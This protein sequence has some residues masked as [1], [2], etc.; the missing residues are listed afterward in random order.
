MNMPTI[1][2]L[3]CATVARA[4]DPSAPTS[5]WV[6]A[7]TDAT[8]SMAWYGAA[9]ADGDIARYRI[10]RDG[11]EVATPTTTNW[12]DSGLQ[13][14][15]VYIYTIVVEDVAGHRSSASAAL[16]AITLPAGAAA[17]PA[18]TGLIATATGCHA[19]S[20]TWTAVTD[21]DPIVRYLIYVDGVLTAASTTPDITLSGLAAGSRG[22]TVRAED[23][24]G[25]Q[26]VASASASATILADLVAPS[27]PG[28]VASAAVTA[29]TMMLSWTAATDN[30][31]VVHYQLD[32]LRNGVAAGSWTT[33]GLNYALGAQNGAPLVPSSTYTITVSAVDGNA[34]STAAAPVVV[35]TL[36]DASPPSRPAP[37]RVAVAD[38]TSMQLAWVHPP[39]DAG[40]VTME[41]LRDGVVLTTTNSG[42]YTDTTVA[43]AIG[44]AYTLVAIDAAGNRSQPSMALAVAA[45][46]ESVAP[47]AP[48]GLRVVS[49]TATSLTFDWQ[50][51]PDVGSGV[52][53]WSIERDGVVIA[54]NVA[55]KPWIDTAPTGQSHTWTVRAI[56]RCGNSSAPSTAL[57]LQRLGDLLPPAAPATP[58]LGQSTVTTAVIDWV[59]VGGDVVGYEIQRD[60]FLVGTSSSTSWTDADRVPASTVTYTVVAYDA[61][62]NHSPPSPGVVSTTPADITAPSVPTNLSASA[63]APDGF[64][65][66]WTGSTDDHRVA[67]Y[68][69]WRAGVQI[70]TAAGTSVILTGLPVGASAAYTVRAVDPTGNASADATAVTVATLAD[71]TAPSQ[72]QAP[73]AAATAPTAITLAWMACDDDVAV[74]SYEIHRDGFVVATTTSPGW[75]DTAVAQGGSYAYALVAIDGVGNRSAEGPGATITVPW[76]AGSDRTPPSVPG[77]VRVALISDR[78]IGIAWDASTDNLPANIKHYVISVDG[79]VVTTTTATSI[80]INALLPAQDY[81]LAVQAEDNAGNRSAASLPFIV[82]TRND[83]APPTVPAGLVASAIG[84]TSFI[85]T[86]QPAVDDIAVDFYEITGPVRVDGTTTTCTDLLPGTAITRSVRAVDTAGNRSGWASIQVTTLPDTIAPSVPT[87]LA[88]ANIT[89]TT[90]TV[91]WTASTDDAGVDRYEVRIGTTTMGSTT[92]TSFQLTGLAPATAKSCTVR[93]IDRTGNAS[94]WSTALGFTNLTDTVSPLPPDGVRITSVTYTSVNLA[95]IAGTDDVA[96]T[97]YRIYVDGVQ[98]A[99]STGT[100]VTVNGL[101]SNQTYTITVRAL[102]A[103]GNVSSD[104]PSIQL[105]M[106]TDGVAPPMPDW[107]TFSTRTTSSIKVHW[108]ATQPD[109]GSGIAGFRVRR[110]GTVV[111]TLVGTGVTNYTIT[112]LSQ[113]TPYAITVASYDNG[114]NES[115]PTFPVTIQLST[116]TVVPTKATNLAVTGTTTNSVSLSWT[117]GTDNIAVAQYLVL[118]NNIVVGATTGTTFT[119]AGVQPSTTGTY[120]LWT[121]DTSGNYSANSTSVSG[122]T[123]ADVTTPTAPGQPVA[124]TMTVKSVPLSWPAGTDET[125][126]KE[127]RVYRNGTLAATVSGTS[128]TD[129]GVVQ[130]QS[131][132]YLVY[133]RDYANHQ[134]SASPSCVVTVPADVTAPAQPG[135]VHLTS[136]TAASIAMTWGPV[137]DDYAVASYELVRDGVV[138]QTTTTTSITNSGL[139]PSHAYDYQL[140]AIDTVGNRSVIGPVATLSTTADT[141]PPASSPVVTLA[142]IT[143]G[144]MRVSWTAVADGQSGIAGY[145][146]LRDGVEVVPLVASSPY[147]LSG[148]APT[149]TYSITVEAIDQ[150]GNRTSGTASATT[151]TD[152]TA[153]GAPT[154]GQPVATASTITVAWSA[155]TDFSG[156][157]GYE[158]SLN[159]TRVVTTPA[160]QWIFTDLRPSMPYRI[161]VVAVDSKGWR[162]TAATVDIETLEDA[163]PPVLAGG[164]SA[165]AGGDGLVT[166]SWLPATDDSGVLTYVVYRDGSEIQRPLTPGCVDTTGAVGAVVAYQIQA[167]DALGKASVVSDAVTVRIQGDVIAPQRVAR[168]T[169]MCTATSVTLSWSASWDAGGVAGYTV[170]RDGVAVAEVTGT[171]WVDSDRVPGSEHRYAVTVR[172]QSGLTSAIS[173]EVVAHLPVDDRVPTAPT[174]LVLCE[175]GTTWLA[176][177]WQAADDGG[178]SGIATYEV[179]VDDVVRATS[180]DLHA[181]FMVPAS[182]ALRRVAVRACDRAGR[183]STWSAALA[184][185]PRDPTASGAAPTW[186]ADA[187][188]PSIPTGLSATLTDVHTAG[189][190]WTASSDANGIAGYLIFRTPSGG[191]AVCCGWTTTTLFTDRLVPGITAQSW[192]VQAVDLFGNLS[193]AA[194]SSALTLPADTVNPAAPLNLRV[195]RTDPVLRRA[196]VAWDLPTGMTDLRAWRVSALATDLEPTVLAVDVTVTFGASVTVSSVDFH[197]H[198]GSASVTVAAPA[199]PPPAPASDMRLLWQSDAGVG[200]A[201]TPGWS[202]HQTT[203]SVIER[204]GVEVAVVSGATWT[205]ASPVA[206]TTHHY[207]VRTRD[208]AG[209]YGVGESAIDVAIPADAIAPVGPAVVAYSA[210]T[211]TAITL[212]WAAATD[213]PGRPSPTYEVSRDG[214]TVA[215]VTA[216]TTTWVDSGLQPD[217][218][219][220]YTIAAID[221]GGNRTTCTAPLRTLRGATTVVRNLRVAASTPGSVTLAWDP[222]YDVAGLTAYSLS[223]LGTTVGIVAPL[224]SGT[225]ACSDRDGGYTCTVTGSDGTRTTDTAVLH[226]PLRSPSLLQRTTAFDASRWTS[227]AGYRSAWLA[228]YDPARLWQPAEPAVGVPVLRSAAGRWLPVAPGGTVN[229]SV[230]GAPDAPVQFLSLSDPVFPAVGLNVITVQADATGTAWASL[231]V[232]RQGIYTVLASSPLASGIV[233]IQ[234]RSQP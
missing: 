224:T 75:T 180:T 211:A 41:L 32:V 60:G 44:H 162:S 176:V 83:L 138:V 134:S 190:S 163:G 33:T 24:Q 56:D 97:S 214:M 92:Q 203:T 122:T 161:A 14:D 65:L 9:D 3:V 85:L 135:V 209:S 221:A 197:G 66:T 99:T 23:S 171:T 77:N 1:L 53:G 10:S 81:A 8:V 188:A 40:V 222:P 185:G 230:V 132:T 31:A 108:Y 216:G 73:W 159:G 95:W 46:T 57:T 78:S 206:G 72:P 88:A 141:T 137:A 71:T 143:D 93:A 165:V 218:V 215:A 146:I 170:W 145:R 157:A 120:Y 82:R 63:L 12:S 179:A 35:N 189:L 131:Y 191:T 58:T 36:A 217:K 107:V 154:M 128:W 193:A 130:N 98:K 80:T 69:I 168:P 233:R 51:D 30:L 100:T 182:T 64:T 22:F 219:H 39:D 173:A 25:N 20:L 109:T 172:D 231:R 102:D 151:L 204:D 118:R 111:G 148:L 101:S 67:S 127:Y 153:P 112:G 103:A 227:D 140:Y 181:R 150:A 187:T 223:C 220:A 17:P 52:V 144:A 90:A 232:P 76:A 160:L 70:A 54:D 104:S 11:V 21:I 199:Q 124:G 106:P 28:S 84:Q 234:V 61:A 139:L 125:M 68:S 48:L 155:A 175:Q 26:S 226:V 169:A 15:R 45:P 91:S 166:L 5:I 110:D 213:S 184:V 156:I 210:R 126:V 195:V 115:L 164:L 200:L 136:A 113:N 129:T 62:G 47:P 117:A 186:D 94:A 228:G 116:D 178:G 167:I 114:G 183:W 13:A 207:A 79:V 152:I 42:G 194:S 96:V 105:V 18:P 196:R 55:S 37:P 208:A 177:A 202:V 49:R 198:L 119:H 29:T 7:K 34:N 201:W 89:S 19:A 123:A 27:A 212:V 142:N 87:G 133:T 2:L 121:V 192:S 205:D 50:Q 86:W 158:V 147:N 4:A 74:A 43:P 229:V 16:Q 6:T 59:G 174:G 38:F 225:I 149:T